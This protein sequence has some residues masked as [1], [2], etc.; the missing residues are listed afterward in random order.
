MF[1]RTAHYCMPRFQIH[2][3]GFWKNLM[4]I[5]P[6]GLLYRWKEY[7]LRRGFEMHFFNPGF[8]LADS[9]HKYVIREIRWFVLFGGYERAQAYITKLYGMFLH[10]TIKDEKLREKLRP[11]FKLGCKRILISDEYYQRNRL[12]GYSNSIYHLI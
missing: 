6:F 11:N 12:N 2:F 4:N 8:Y 5:Y 1:Q 9:I 7:S 10:G 3:G